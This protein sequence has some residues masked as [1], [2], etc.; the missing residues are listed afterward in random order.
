MF[1]SPK[2]NLIVPKYAKECWENAVEVVEL[3]GYPENKEVLFKLFELFRD[4]NWPG[5]LKALNYLQTLNLEVTTLLLENACIKAIEENDTDWL[6]FL[7]EI[8][9]QMNIGKN[10]FQN[11]ALYEQMK[12]I[13]TES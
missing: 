12:K 4:L 1:S 2:L 7:F 3:V 5:S 8:S 6:Y 13:Y 9:S 10:N 11:I